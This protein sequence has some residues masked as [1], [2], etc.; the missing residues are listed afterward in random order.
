[1]HNIVISLSQ[2]DAS[3][4][5]YLVNPHSYDC[6]RLLGVI[7]FLE[8]GFLVHLSNVSERITNNTFANNFTSQAGRQ[9]VF[10]PQDRLCSLQLKRQEPMPTRK[11]E[12]LCSIFS[13][14][15]KHLPILSL[16]PSVLLHRRSA[17][18]LR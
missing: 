11:Q 5:S 14:C 9:E 7:E 15:R 17:S 16:Y 2:G 3:V 8:K 6:I 12:H 13:V 4:G 1:M 18:R 10:T